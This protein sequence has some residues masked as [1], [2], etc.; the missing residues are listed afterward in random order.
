[1][2]K[3]AD[4]V[5]TSAN[6]AGTSVTWMKDAISL[7]TVPED[8]RGIAE[9]VWAGKLDDAREAADIVL[10]NRPEDYYALHLAGVIAL[11]ESR[12][13]SA[14][15]LFH[16]AV[17]RAY[18]KT[19]EAASWNGIGRAMIGLHQ[20]AQAADAFCC[21][22]QADPSRSV[23]AMD[24]AQELAETGKLNQAEEVLRNE[25]R[26]HPQ[27][28]GPPTRLA[29]VWIRHGRHQDALVLLDIAQL[30]DANYA[31]AYFNA[32][33]ALA[34]LGKTDKAYKA[35]CAALKLDPTISGYY[36]LARLGEVKDE[37]VRMLEQRVT[38]GF[39]VTVDGRIDAGFALAV[40]FEGRGEYDQAFRYLQVANALKHSTL[41]YNPGDSIELVRRSKAFFVPALFDRL[42]GKVHCDL[43]PIFI[44][45]MPRSGSTLVEQM[46]AS[47]PNVQAGGEL[48]YLP[49]ICQRVGDIW[50]ARGS[51]SP[52]NDAEV[53]T[54]L[55]QACTEYALLTSSLRRMHTRF[56]DKLPGNYLLLGMI[57][58][59]FPR[60]MIVHTRRN[61]F[62]SCL[63]CYEQLFS[64]RMDFTY[65]LY[66]LGE[67][68]RLYEEIM[69]H[70]HR[71]LPPGRILSVDYE[72]VVSEPETQLR[73]LLSYCGLPYDASCLEF[74]SLHRAVTTASASQVRKP[75][76]RSS[77]G[78]WRHYRH[79]LKPLADALHQPL[80]DGTDSDRT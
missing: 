35:C 25:M 30:A 57:Q 71:V 18:N 59:M 72:S 24:F 48:P 39:G 78:R 62:D 54:D 22:M 43:Q 19:D 37:Q 10:R 26:R 74:Q 77:V 42:M 21:A 32:S 5:I 28:A 31:P 67:R 40:V 76:Y 58:L 6:A 4:H 16:Y 29:S 53:I 33:V 69:D 11:N 66:D 47:H 15:E 27:D 38:Q 65:D 3:I 20:H 34:M 41:D 45:G 61:P 46:L 8:V 1:M 73:R 12:F 36:L 80:P 14:I 2:T 64:S 23:H 75:I 68:Y 79:H 17:K 13:K 63:S 9:R 7:S 50:G 56:T 49:E 44:V 52:G 51:A 60:A 70:W 55:E